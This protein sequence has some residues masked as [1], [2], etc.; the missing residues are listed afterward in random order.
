MYKISHLKIVLVLLF[1]LVGVSSGY[2]G[3][4]NFEN[5]KKLKNTSN[6]QAKPITTNNSKIS[7][8]DISDWKYFQN[9]KYGFWFKYPSYFE[10]NDSSNKGISGTDILLYLLTNGT[11]YNES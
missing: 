2:A 3:W 4:K 8:T 9:E 5:N 6:T 1:V 11:K 7:E 10:V